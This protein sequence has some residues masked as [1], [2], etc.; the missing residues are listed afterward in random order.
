MN[1][2][3]HQ[4]L[5]SNILELQ[6]GNFI[7]D[8]LRG[9]DFKKLPV[10][11]LKGV[12]LHRKIDAFTDSHPA[13]QEG[14]EL[15]KPHQGRYSSVVM[16]V[17]LDYFLAKNW[18]HFNQVSLEEWS[19]KLYGSFKQNREVFPKKTREA[20]D[21]L[22]TNDW[23]TSYGNKKGLYYPF[24]FMKKRLSFENRME[25]AIEDLTLL[26]DQLEPLFF[27][28]YPEIM[29]MSKEFIEEQTTK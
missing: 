19:S 29:K 6:V 21:S 7:A 27:A 17:Y 8:F 10:G 22:V 2:L 12:E 16:D 13:V 14:V 5:S 23:F 3:A 11:V 1:F 9:I 28:F 18:G 24:H 4:H 26:E 15:L 25:F 20:L